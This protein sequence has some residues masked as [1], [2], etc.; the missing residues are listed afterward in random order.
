MIYILMHK[1]I[2]VAKLCITEDG[3]I[4]EITEVYDIAR[5]PVNSRKLSQWWENRAIPNNRNGVGHMLN[6]L[7]SQSILDQT[8]KCFCLSLSDHYWIQSENQN[9]NWEKLNFYDNDFSD[10]VGKILFGED[11]SNKLIDLNSPDITTNGCLKKRWEIIDGKQYLVK[12]GS[13]P[14]LQQPIN[15]VV[16]GIIAGA[17]GINCVKYD[18]IWNKEELFSVC[19]NFTAKD[20][21]FVSAWAVINSVEENEDDALYDRFIKRCISNGIDD[22]KDDINRM[23]VLDYIIGN[24]DRHLFNFGIMRNSNTLEWIGIAPIFDCGNSLG[25]NKLNRQIAADCYTQK[26]PFGHIYSEQLD[27]S[28]VD[29]DAL[30][31][32]LPTIEAILLDASKKSATLD[33]KR[34]IKILEFIQKQIEK[35]KR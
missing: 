16:A 30:E 6:K 4:T 15:E 20:T 32:A 19:E 10:S 31:K 12:G 27:F 8:P 21:E 25:Y 22:V 24:E 35:M 7:D 9:Q 18:M 14:F 23:L 34:A 33:E 26:L 5:L 17:L 11:I 13:F 3:S 28:W 2:A 1:N 29:F